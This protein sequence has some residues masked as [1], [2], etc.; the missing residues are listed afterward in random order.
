MRRAHKLIKQIREALIADGAHAPVETL[1]A[2][3]ARC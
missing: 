2:D 3:Y 1:A